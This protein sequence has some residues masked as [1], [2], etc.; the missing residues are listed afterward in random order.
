MT[1]NIYCSNHVATS[2]PTQ[3]KEEKIKEEKTMCAVIRT[4]KAS[5]LS[6]FSVFSGKFFEK[7][8]HVAPLSLPPKNGWK[9]WQSLNC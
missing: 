5:I 2:F 8:R 3:S 6:M 1:M 9:K 4:F 7:V